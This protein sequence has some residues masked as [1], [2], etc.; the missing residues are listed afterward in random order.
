MDCSFFKCKTQIRCRRH[1]VVPK[2][3]PNGC[4]R[5]SRPVRRSLRN[6]LAAPLGAVLLHVAFIAF[7]FQVQTM[8]AEYGAQVADESEWTWLPE[9]TLLA[10]APSVP[11]APEP[12]PPPEP[13]PPPPTPPPSEPV[14]PTP[15]PPPPLESEIAPEI[16][17]PLPEPEPTPA[18]EPPPLATEVAVSTNGPDAWT[19]VRSEVLDALRYPAPARRHNVEG[20]VHLRLELDEDGNV[21]ALDVQPPRTARTLDEA[22]LAAVRRAAPFPDAGDAIRR[23]AIPP[24]A[25]F[26][27]RFELRKGSP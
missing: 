7:L 24:I 1:L 8:R 23:G 5:A 12:P 27:I 16:P 26:P 6:R 19:Q 2:G 11:P 13:L 4:G 18:P 3:F 22:V 14:L 17:P 15:P 10:S 20:T 9:V 21:A 25:E